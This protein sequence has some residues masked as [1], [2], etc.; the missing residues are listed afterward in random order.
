MDCTG[1]TK[2]AELVYT[3]RLQSSVGFTSCLADLVSDLSMTEKHELPI[4][5]PFIANYRI[6]FTS[7]PSFTSVAP[8]VM[9]R[10][11]GFKPAFTAIRFP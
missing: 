11:A 8:V 10:S 6:T 7:H 3:A 4:R 2:P 5:N 1:R 9:M